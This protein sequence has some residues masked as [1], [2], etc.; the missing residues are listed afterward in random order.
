MTSIVQKSPSP[1]ST[2][3]SHHQPLGDLHR[4]KET[5][6]YIAACPQSVLTIAP[7][8]P[9][10]H[11]CPRPCT[12]LTYAQLLTRSSRSPAPSSRCSH[13]CVHRLL[14]RTVQR[15]TSVGLN[16]TT[17][18]ETFVC[19]FFWASYSYIYFWASHSH[20]QHIFVL[21]FSWIACW[22]YLTAQLKKQ[23]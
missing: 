8:A 14:I 15:S 20:H 13:L 1:S 9:R 19:K 22:A 2:I 17:T 3:I 5:T 12:L 16:I 6:A 23:F 21:G 18:Q 4:P 10:P 11:L 7:F